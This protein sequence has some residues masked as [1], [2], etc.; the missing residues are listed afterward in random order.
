MC[1]IL[2]HLKA[3]TSATDNVCFQ[4]PTKLSNISF[5]EISK[6]QLYVFQ[7]GR[8]PLHYAA[9]MDH[10]DVIEFF[11]ENRPQLVNQAN[12]VSDIIRLDL[13]PTLDQV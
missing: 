5:L 6:F 1:K 12:A 13:Y 10:S 2:L 7:K 4:F 3:D 11:L 9:Q 8:T